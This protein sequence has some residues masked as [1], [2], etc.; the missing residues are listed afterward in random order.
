MACKHFVAVITYQS[1]D[2]VVFH[3]PACWFTWDWSHS[4]SRTR[5]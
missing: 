2:I 3:C 4:L 1:T 5:H